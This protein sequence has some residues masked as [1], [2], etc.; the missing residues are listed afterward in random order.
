MTLL[1]SVLS[2]CNIH[3]FRDVRIKNRVNV[4]NV[5]CKGKIS[6]EM[7]SFLACDK[8]KGGLCFIFKDKGRLCFILLYSVC[9]C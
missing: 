9:C 5:L 4:T 2:H 7:N 3:M 8:G 1:F 6:M